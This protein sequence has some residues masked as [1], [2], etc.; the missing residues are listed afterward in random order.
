MLR[1]PC[2]CAL[3]ARQR[4]QHARLPIEFRPWAAGQH[5]GPL[6]PGARCAEDA[7]AIVQVLRCTRKWMGGG[8][9][10]AGT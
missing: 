9:G 2:L 4:L 7:I 1:P 3:T 6:R 10:A 5:S 8:I